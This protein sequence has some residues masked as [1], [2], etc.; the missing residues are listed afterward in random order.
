MRSLVPTVIL[1][2]MAVM[3][4]GAERKPNI[5]FILADDLGYGGLGCYGQRKYETPN[6]DRLAAEGM[7]F[8]RMHAGSHVC[9]PSRSTLMTGLHTGRTPVRANGRKRFLHDAD[10]TVAERLKAAGYATGG[11]GKWGLGLADTEGAA[12]KQGFDEWFGQ[13]SQMH[14]HFFY[15]FWVWD[16]LRRHPLP[17]NEGGKRGQYVFDETHA[18]ALDFIRRKRDRPF[19][20]YLPY[21]IPHVELVVPEDS[22][23][24]FRGKFPRTRIE[25]P[26][27]GYI[28]SD[29]GFAT[30]AGMVTRLDRAVGEVM[31]LLKELRLDEDT[32]VIFSSDNGP[33]GGSESGGKGVWQQLVE[34]FDGNG[35]L[36]GAKSDFYEGGTRVPFIARWPGRI[37]A[38]AV[39]GHLGAFWDVMPTL[40]EIA[41]AEPPEMTDGVSLVP[42]LLGRP[43]QKEH[44]FLYW[45]YPYA[46]LT[47]C[48][49][50]GPW[51]LIKNRPRRE[52]ELYNIAADEAET[53]NVAE[54]HPEVVREL[55]AIAAREHTPEREYPE[56]DPRERVAD[57][58]R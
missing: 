30:Y 2:L 51:K 25:D 27:P 43:G 32:M 26:R 53:T 17:G 28:S 22:E 36:R 52:W 3:G 41:G 5:I 4:H 50:R 19:F 49:R 29:D 13:Y 45:E 9:A 7:R 18:R 20:A 33:Q 46:G 44:E 57:F 42:K 24:P 16:G 47:Q 40:C 56:L 1:L 54:Q 38:G 37:R 10:V 11:F 21:I 48:V 31:A 23:A 55:Q 15:P 39:S 58:V 6:L 14:A 35:P 8:T 34:F 12:V